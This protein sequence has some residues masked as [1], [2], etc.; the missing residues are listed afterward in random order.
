MRA[1][2]LITRAHLDVAAPRRHLRRRNANTTCTTTTT[3]TTRGQRVRRVPRPRL[4]RRHRLQIHALPRLI[5]PRD[6]A[7]AQRRG[8]RA[9]RRRVAR[10]AA[11]L[12]DA[13]PRGDELRARVRAR[14]RRR[15]RRVACAAVLRA[16]C[17]RDEVAAWRAD[18]VL[19]LLLLY[20]R[21]LLMRPRAL[22]AEDLEQHELR[23]PVR[24]VVAAEQGREL[25]RGV[26]R[27]VVVRVGLSTSTSTR[28]DA[29]DELSRDV[30]RA[31]VEHRAVEQRQAPRDEV[32]IEA[33]QHLAREA[34]LLEHAPREAAPRR[35]RRQPP[36]RRVRMWMRM[37]VRMRPVEGP[38]ILLERQVQRVHERDHLA[39]GVRRARR[40][41]V[42]VGRVRAADDGR[43]VEHRLRRRRRDQARGACAAAAFVLG[44]EHRVRDRL[45]LPLLPR[46]SVH[47]LVVIPQILVRQPHD[48]LPICVA[49]LVF[50]PADEIRA[51][52]HKLGLE[53]LPPDDR[54]DAE[55]DGRRELVPARLPAQ[56]VLQ[57]RGLCRVCAL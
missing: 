13:H 57:R 52:A 43:G 37:R 48:A 12:A 56:L 22:G 27:V 28:A 1:R 26:R 6:G 40:E 8:H 55:D 5:Q 39:R 46:R 35:R 54:R 47:R 20:R 31:L 44:A 23:E 2:K 16:P 17:R 49:R 51:A 11:Q 45:A 15:R 4:D 7:R 41:E 30:S 53:G 14:R 21:V 34:L 10:R 29:E 9:P 50:G 36:A 38:V 3:T 42:D 24:L 25:R 18:V 33:Q 32:R 19:L